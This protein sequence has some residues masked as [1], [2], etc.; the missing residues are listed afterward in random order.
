M[1]APY[2]NTLS[3]GFDPF[4]PDGHKEWLRWLGTHDQAPRHNTDYVTAGFLPVQLPE[5]EDGSQVRRMVYVTFFG[6]RF[7]KICEFAVRP[8]SSYESTDTSY[9]KALD[10]DRVSLLLVFRRVYAEAV[11]VLYST[12]TFQLMNCGIGDFLNTVGPVGSGF[13][14]SIKVYWDSRGGTGDTQYT[15]VL[16]KLAALPQFRRL[17]IDF[18]GEPTSLQRSATLMAHRIYSTGHSLDYRGHCGYRSKPWQ[19][20]NEEPSSSAHESID[21]M[22]LPLSARNLVYE[23]LLASKPLIRVIQANGSLWNKDRCS[24]DCRTTDI[25]RVNKQINSEAAKV[26]YGKNTI[27][28]YNPDPNLFLE[29]IGP[30]NMLSLRSLE[31]KHLY[32]LKS[33]LHPLRTALGRLTSFPNIRVSLG[34]DRMSVPRLYSIV[35]SLRA[36]RDAA[37]KPL[38]GLAEDFSK[39]AEDISWVV[40][41]DKPCCWDHEC[42]TWRPF[43]EVVTWDLVERHRRD[44]RTRL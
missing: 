9:S 23:Y 15:R 21:F 44:Q 24:P 25:L 5:P 33:H 40:D 13:L 37:R 14:Q 32:S 1:A 16:R 12:C 4:G 2:Y 26:L 7:H 20:D 6:D 31:L 39:F 29:Q 10:V 22:G 8:I 11:E 36:L 27:R 34:V 3:D 43:A 38:T 17:V 42:G 30:T 35:F 28:P 19:S 18:F 41:L